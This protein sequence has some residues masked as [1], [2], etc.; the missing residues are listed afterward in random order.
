M[1][2]RLGYYYAD[3]R[4]LRTSDYDFSF[5]F[6]NNQGIIRTFILVLLFQYL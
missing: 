3:G 4:C 5:N 2:C 6:E 1:K